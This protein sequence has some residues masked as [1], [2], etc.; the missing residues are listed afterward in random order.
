MVRAESPC[1][2]ALQFIPGISP[3]PVFPPGQHFLQLATLLSLSLFAVYPE[4]SSTGAI[5]LHSGQSHSKTW[6]SMNGLFISMPGCVAKHLPW[7]SLLMCSCS[8][9][10]HGPA[11]AIPSSLF[12]CC[13][14]LLAHHEVNQR[15]LVEK[16]VLL[17]MELSQLMGL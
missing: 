5:L 2:R 1:H 4:K 13:Q 11:S 17:Y 12:R 8:W 7:G 14:C 6:C 10:D 9:K 15:E 3:I 16:M